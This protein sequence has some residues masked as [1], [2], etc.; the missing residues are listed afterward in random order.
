MFAA[1]K[2]GTDL[3]AGLMRFRVATWGGQ[4]TTQDEVEKRLADAGFTDVR[5]LPGPPRDFK[6]IL[7]ARRKQNA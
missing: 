6:M 4:P 7:A 2:P 5:V 3:R 1:A